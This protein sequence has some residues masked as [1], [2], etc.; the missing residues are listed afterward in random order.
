MGNVNEAGI[1]TPGEGETVDPEVWSAA[2]AD[3]IMNGLGERMNKQET[4]AAGKVSINAPVDVT[5]DGIT[6]P[7]AVSTDYAYSYGNYVE[8]L[9]LESGI[10]KI[11]TSGVYMVIGSVI[12]D[13]VENRTPMNISLN[14]NTDIAI[15][16]ALET[17]PTTWASK[18]LITSGYLIAG[19]LVYM[20]AAT[21]A[22]V[23]ENLP[24]RGANL[25]VLML[26]AT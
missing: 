5:P 22:G 14:F 26:H 24:V 12:C 17:S 4:K 6:F 2:M 25:N 16:E 13:F 20:R 15:S 3:S 7:L 21:A 19:D 8:G 1:W 9:E 11:L 18:T 10:I 23:Q